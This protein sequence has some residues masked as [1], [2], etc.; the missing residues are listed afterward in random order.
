MARKRNSR[1]WQERAFEE[2]ENKRRVQDAG[3]TD[4]PQPLRTSVDLPRRSTWRWTLGGVAAIIVA[5]LIRH[6]LDARAPALTTNCTTPA[7]ALSTT[8]TDQ[9]VN[10]RW[11]ATGPA[12]ARFLI[13]IGVATLK[14]GTDPGQL[15]PV[16]DPGNDLSHTQLAVPASSL[17]ATCIAHGAFTVDIPKGMYNVRMF[18]INGTGRAT[19]GTPVATKPLKVSS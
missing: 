13:A 10:V 6:G 4:L 14:P 12:N 18:T 3:A 9:G 17:N 15:S 19:T 1:D 8:H 2:T 11:S 7:I 5:V 16:P